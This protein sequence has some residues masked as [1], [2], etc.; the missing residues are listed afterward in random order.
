MLLLSNRYWR[1][2]GTFFAFYHIHYRTNNY[3]ADQDKVYKNYNFSF[4]G[5]DG[6]V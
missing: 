1:D 4:T 6:L 3:G 2:A 5:G